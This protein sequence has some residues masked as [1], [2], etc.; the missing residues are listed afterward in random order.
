M[1]P[2]PIF[3]RAYKNFQHFLR[4]HER[5]AYGSLRRRWWSSLRPWLL[6]SVGFLF[7]FLGFWFFLLVSPWWLISIGFGFVAPR[8]FTRIQMM[9]ASVFCSNWSSCSAWP[10]PC[11]STVSY[12]VDFFFFQG[13]DIFSIHF[14]VW[15]HS[16]FDGGVVFFCL[17]WSCLISISKILY[18]C[19]ISMLFRFQ[20]LVS[21]ESI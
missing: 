12:P 3:L 17:S 20:M 18:C 10:I 5:C 15:N 6:A 2:N 13:F 14:V 1:D 7:E 8:A 9:G 21:Q 19:L 16:P 11:T 4:A